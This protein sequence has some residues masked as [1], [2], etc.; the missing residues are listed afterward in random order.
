MI[1]E[2][3]PSML[4]RGRFW[5]VL[6]HP[7][8]SA[9]AWYVPLIHI[10]EGFWF[11]RSFPRRCDRVG[12]DHGAN[13]PHLFGTAIRGPRNR[14][15][16]CFASW[17]DCLVVADLKYRKVIIADETEH[18]RRLLER[19]ACASCTC[20]STT[21]TLSELA[22]QFRVDQATACSA[23]LPRFLRPPPTVR[24]LAPI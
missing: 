10:K 2:R 23:F 19:F 17:T 21:M 3:F 8:A 13:N 20:T 7:R 5:V 4:N 14:N 22:S 24:K 1:P 15:S 9:R 16:E 12:E 6:P 11:S 18:N